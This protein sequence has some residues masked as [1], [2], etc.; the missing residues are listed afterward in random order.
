MASCAQGA[1][2][3]VLSASVSP[4]PTQV[5]LHHEEHEQI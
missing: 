1:L 3:V 5:Q 4:E 2:A